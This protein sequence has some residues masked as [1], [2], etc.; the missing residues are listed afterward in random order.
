MS[1]AYTKQHFKVQQFINRIA[2]IADT[3]CLI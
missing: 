1:C 3:H 2:V